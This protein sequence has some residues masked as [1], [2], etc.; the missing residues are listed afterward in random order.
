MIL[1]SNMAGMVRRERLAGRDYLVAP[2]VLISP[3]VLRGS[4]GPLMYTLADIQASAD[5]W[6]GMPIVRNHPQGPG[7]RSISA[8]NPH[9]WNKYGLGYVYNVRVN[10]KLIAE[11]WIDVEKTRR[12]DPNILFAVEQGRQ[13]EVST[14][15]GVTR[16]QTIGVYGGKSYKAIAR[17]YQPDHLAILTD[18]R[19]ACSLLDGCGL[20]VA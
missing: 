9:V 1:T 11:A 6:N 15:L 10:G 4:V 8:R 19:G 7:G 20:N 16:E 18:Q 13:L 2:L 3:G 12:V 17:N 14:G 5:S